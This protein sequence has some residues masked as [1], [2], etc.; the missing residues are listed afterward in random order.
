ME[1][2]VEPFGFSLGDISTTVLIGMLAGLV[3]DLTVGYVV[4]RTL[5]Y[6]FSYI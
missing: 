3:G 2:V 5:A 6:K 4:K 1:Y